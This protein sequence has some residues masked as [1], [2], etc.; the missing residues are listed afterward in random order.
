MAIHPVVNRTPIIL[1]RASSANALVEPSATSIGTNQYT[2][3]IGFGGLIFDL[4]ILFLA[5][6]GAGAT[7]IIE[8]SPTDNFSVVTVP[9][10]RTD[11][12]FYGGEIDVASYLNGQ[13]LTL[14]NLEGSGRWRVKNT[15]TGA[16]QVSYRYKP[17]RS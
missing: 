6:A 13:Q 4:D 9:E 15:G 3:A 5:D 10:L 14:K 7:V 16:I 1:R 2:Q 12:P 8:T 17:N 11:P